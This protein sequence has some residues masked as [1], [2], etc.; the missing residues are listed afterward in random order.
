M[1]GVLGGEDQGDAA[2]L[3][4]RDELLECVRML[5]EFPGVPLFERVPFRWV[6]PEP[7]SQAGAR[8]QILEPGVDLELVLDG[9]GQFRR[10]PAVMMI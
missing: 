2:S 1:L 9:L 6:V 7:F 3:G 5:L 4:S 8:R 10:Q